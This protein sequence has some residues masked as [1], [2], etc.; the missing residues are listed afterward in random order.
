[1]AQLLLGLPVM[2]RYGWALRRIRKAI[3]RASTRVVY[4][5]RS[6]GTAAHLRQRAVTHA[7]RLGAHWI[8][9]IL[10]VTTKRA[11]RERWEARLLE[12]LPAALRR[13]RV[14]CNQTVGQNGRWP[15][16]HKCVLYVAL[17]P[18]AR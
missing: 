11:S 18:A 14:L 13:H 12:D 9:P 6:A 16:T 7:V 4:I 10:L 2:K 5:G 15:S 3:E 17:C 8:A 1:M